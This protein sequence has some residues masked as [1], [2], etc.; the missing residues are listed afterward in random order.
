MTAHNAQDDD[1]FQRISIHNVGDT[2]KRRLVEG[3]FEI[4]QESDLSNCAAGRPRCRSE[5]GWKG[6]VEKELQATGQV[7]RDKYAHERS[8][9]N[10]AEAGGRTVLTSGTS[11]NAGKY[12]TRPRIGGV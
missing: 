1:G 12:A 11:G 8:V 10:P 9:G 5:L 7:M 3:Q 6:E 2:D 4:L